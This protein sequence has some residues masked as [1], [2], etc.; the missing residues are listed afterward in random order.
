MST[1]DKAFLMPQSLSPNKE[2]GEENKKEV[3]KEGKENEEEENKYHF[4]NKDLEKMEVTENNITEVAKALS[5]EMYDLVD[6][7]NEAGSGWQLLDKIQ[8][9]TNFLTDKLEKNRIEMI[10]HDYSKNKKSIIEDQQYTEYKNGEGTT[11]GVIKCK[12][13]EKIHYYSHDDGW[14]FNIEENER[15]L[16]RFFYD[17]IQDIIKEK[18]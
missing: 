9:I 6:F 4:L 17:L 8:E 15:Q 7:L 1:I 18:I 10:V 11:Y 12:G 16:V 14:G 2:R 13:I 3:K 5:D